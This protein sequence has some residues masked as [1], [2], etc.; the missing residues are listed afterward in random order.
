[1]DAEADSGTCYTKSC[2]EPATTPCDRCGHAFCL[3]HVRHLVIQR[4][5]ERSQRPTH[6]GTLARLPT[7]AETY[8]LCSHCW[9]K[10]VPCKT[11]QVA[12]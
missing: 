10:P 5:E 7:R 12:L 3:A 8:A 9:T 4:R 2:T 11:S 1:M 6:L